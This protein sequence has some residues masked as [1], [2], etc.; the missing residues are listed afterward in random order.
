MIEFKPMTY[1]E[2]RKQMIEEITR[3]MPHESVREGSAMMALIESIASVEASFFHQ[4]YTYT[5]SP[6]EQHK[7]AC[8]HKWVEVGFMHTKM[9][10][11]HCDVEQT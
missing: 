2:L 8:D 11:K 4:M 10:C 9:V 1:E 7:T 3:R 5:I 6:A